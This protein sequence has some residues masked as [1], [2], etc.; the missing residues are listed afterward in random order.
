MTV[1][2]N[3]RFIK[4]KKK[5]EPSTGLW[6]LLNYFFMI[7]HNTLYCSRTFYRKTWIIR[8]PLCLKKIGLDSGG[9]HIMS[10]NHR[11]RVKTRKLVCEC[12]VLQW[13]GYNIRVVFLSEW[14][15]TVRCNL[16]DYFKSIFKS[17][18][19]LAQLVKLFTWVIYR[20]FFEQ[21]Q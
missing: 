13:Y 11:H 1:S 9:G 15:F 6:R 20:S 14:G 21:S 19:L 4:E 7:K 3:V 12:I 17:A 2:V 18:F 8:P 16:N 5:H 10:L